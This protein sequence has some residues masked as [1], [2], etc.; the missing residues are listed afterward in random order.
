MP[1]K[2]GGSTTSLEEGGRVEQVERWILELA[3]K[4]EYVRPIYKPYVEGLENL[5]AD[6][7]FLLVGNH[8][9][10]ASTEILL[11]PYEVHRQIGYK[12]RPLTDLHFGRM[13]GLQAD[14]LKAAGAIIGTPDGTRALMRADEPILVFPGGARE[15]SKGKD[16]LYTLLW[17]D[18][19]GFARLAVEHNYP[20][21]TA[22][23]VGGDDVYKILTTRHGWWGRLNKAVASLSGARQD[24]TIQLM[25]GI[26]PTLLPRPQ[27]L[28]AR[29]SE[30]IDTT[31]PDGVS[32]EDWV[33]KVRE[34]AKSS[35]EADL[36]DLQRIRSTDPFRHL[37]P[38]AWRSAVMPPAG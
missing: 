7:R 32:S 30:P 19:A 16:E 5:P 25:R 34:M 33:A 24:M 14:V 22:A 13:K 4:W 6:G 18:R 15:I 31:K 23:V 20:I 10:T 37:A 8:T 26:G 38:W 28:Y 3:R 11:V 9:A 12:V 29:F 2:A 1:D 35:L 17:G 36:A 21:V 27:R